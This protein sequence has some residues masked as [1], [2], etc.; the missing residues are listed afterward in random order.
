MKYVCLG[1]H[2]ERAWGALPE[3]ERKALLA[4]TLAYADVLRE[5]GHLIEEQAL[6]AAS[7]ATTLRFSGGRML[8]CD[9][10]FAETKEQ[11]GGFM[12]L[13]ANDLNHAIQ[14]AAKMPCM[15]VGGSLEIRPVNEE[16][17]EAREERRVGAE[18]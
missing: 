7:S 6:Q 1:Y 10:P 12:V 9:G 17:A 16:M 13:E 11:L 15:R 18:A 8:I 5:G 3:A 2:D 14:L 4:E